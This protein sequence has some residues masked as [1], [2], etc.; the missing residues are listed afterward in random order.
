M[1]DTQ[2]N[3]KLDTSQTR[4]A[5]ETFDA[6]TITRPIPA[7]HRYYLVISIF[8]LILFPFVYVP[9]LIRYKTM[10]YSF[11]DTGVSMR[12]GYFFR[13]EVYLT[14][15]RLQDIHVTR[16]IIER[17]MGLAKVPIQTASGTSG[18]TMKIEGVGDPE[19]LRDFLYERMRGARA[20]DHAAS[21]DEDSNEKITS[22]LVE[23]RDALREDRVARGRDS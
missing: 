16:N 10:R 2:D 13:H 22:L 14:Y 8:A 5:A 20:Y 1:G 21:D 9:F 23:I 6:T 11:D 17:W 3:I 19:G 12:W 18:A 15:R 7:L 4:S